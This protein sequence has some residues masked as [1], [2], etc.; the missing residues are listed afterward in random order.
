[1]TLS[2]LIW[3]TLFAGIFSFWWQS[4]VVKHL[5]LGK[6]N[7]YCERLGLQLLDH[8][9]VIR[10]ILPARSASGSL[11]LR[12]RYRFEFTSTGEERYR[13]TLTMTGR[14]IDSIEVEPHL[15]P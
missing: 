12:R 14:L 11:C 4:D 5:A 1:M 13:G 10:S 7:T 6:A 9:M 3:L 8:T 15:L 2:L